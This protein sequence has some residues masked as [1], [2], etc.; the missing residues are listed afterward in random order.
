[1]P[2]RAARPLVRALA[3]LVAVTGLA[4]WAAGGRVVAD[5]PA[6]EKPVAPPAAAPPGP[7]YKNPAV[8]I[9]ITGPKG[10]TLKAGSA[11]STSWKRLASFSEPNTQVEVV[12]S[13]RDRTTTTLSDLH[14]AVQKEW[15][16]DKTY[17][18][19][20]V[21]LT[22]PT[23][24]RPVGMVQVDATQVRKAAAA[25]GA[26]P[27][28]AAPAQ[29]LW[30]LLVSYVVTQRYEVLLHAS[31]PAVAWPRA[32]G[33]VQTLLDT[34]ALAA[35]PR[36]PEG[37]GAYRNDERGFGIRYPK[38]YTVIVPGRRDHVVSFAPT[39]GDLPLLEVYLIEWKDEVAKD[40]ERLVAHFTE[41]R[42]GNASSRAA[43]VA[44]QPGML[45]TA[46]V[47]ESG[48]D[49]TVLLALFK[50]GEELFRLRASMPATAEAAGTPMFDEFV[51]SFSLTAAR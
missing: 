29:T 49:S 4:S 43:D 5:P 9:T 18:V 22:D 19:S 32:R 21:R 37:E 25:P 51:R 35:A 11:E 20:S 24:L 44:G 13:S 14:A 2:H 28:A 7:V 6:P 50:R 42:G 30:N 33:A 3:A 39:A 12:V 45:V 41:A 34:I 40:A 46:H 47:N 31:G 17:N 26:A 10:W 38:G 8:G 15:E 16:A 36:G 48:R 23:A 1:M 27:S